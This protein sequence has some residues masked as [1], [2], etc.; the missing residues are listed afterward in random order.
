L[1]WWLA[2]LATLG[3]YFINTTDNVGMSHQE[4]DK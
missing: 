2:I 3:I 4:I 1:D